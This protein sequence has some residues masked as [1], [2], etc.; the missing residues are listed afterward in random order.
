MLGNVVNGVLHA[1]DHGDRQ[2]VIQKFRVKILGAGGGAVRQGG[3]ALIQTQLYGRCPG[4]DAVGHQ[5]LLQH[6]QKRGGN[7]AVY[8]QDLLG[9]AD[10]GAAGLGVFDNAHCHL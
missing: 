1:V 7:I 6:G 8:Q 9:V 5:A 10:A 4:G 3:G 2:L